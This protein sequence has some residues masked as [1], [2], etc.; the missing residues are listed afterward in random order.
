MFALEGSAIRH[1]VNF[2]LKYGNVSRAAGDD[3]LE[4]RTLSLSRSGSAVIQKKIGGRFE[5]NEVASMREVSRTWSSVLW[6]LKRD[7]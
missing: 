1:Q 7:P 6:F 5:V 4:S 3:A 2:A